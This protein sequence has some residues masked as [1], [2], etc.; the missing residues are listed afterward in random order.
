MAGDPMDA[1]RQEILRVR[2]ERKND[3]CHICG[4]GET[5]R[6]CDSNGNRECAKCSG[7]VA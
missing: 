2:E 6:F 4:S 5:V 7:E 1:L 3:P